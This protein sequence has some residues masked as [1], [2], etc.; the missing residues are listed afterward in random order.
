MDLDD[1]AKAAAAALDSH[2]LNVIAEAGGIRL[3]D[4]P[5]IAVAGADDPLFEG[6]KNGAVVGPAHLG[7]REWL[8]EARSVASFFF[9][10]SERVRRSNRGLGLPSFEWLYGRIEGESLIRA[11]VAAAVGAIRAAGGRAVAPT[12]DPRFGIAERRSNWSERHVAFISG[13]GTFSLSRS[14]ITQ[15]GS[16]GRLGSLVTDLTLEATP[17]PYTEPEEYCSKCRA[18]IPRC[19][20]KAISALGKDNAVCSDYLDEMK[21]RFA[22]R[23]GCGK[24][25]T[26]LPCEAGIPPRRGS[27]PSVPTSPGAP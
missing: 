20:P 6:L 10:F 21:L 13:L 17:R 18:C 14:L 9:P 22:P 4:P 19:P 15:A 3:Y 24:C 25:Q 1:I 16:A 5:L 2:P 12:S 26:A 8:P 7:P 23:Y 11:V 27:A